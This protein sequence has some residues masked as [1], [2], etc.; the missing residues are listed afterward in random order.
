L[1][2]RIADKALRDRQ[3]AEQ[4]V[5]LDAMGRGQCPPAE[6]AA[7]AVLSFLGLN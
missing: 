7:A 4:F 6:K 3:I 5:A 1:D 2:E